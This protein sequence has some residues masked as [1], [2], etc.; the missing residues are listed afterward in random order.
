MIGWIILL[1][2]IVFVA[3]ILIRTLRF[4]PEKQEEVDIKPVEL[5]EEKIV[6]DMVDM[7]RCKTVSYRDE[8]LVDRAEFVKFEE[9]LKERFPL[10]HENC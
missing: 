5:N 7:I 2:A 10:I 4:K 1:L 6:Q 8:S 9:L 3:V